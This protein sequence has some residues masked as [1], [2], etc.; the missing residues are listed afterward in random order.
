MAGKVLLSSAW[1]SKNWS[2]LKLLKDSHRANNLKKLVF[3][4]NYYFN[5][6]Q[7]SWNLYGWIE[8][9]ETHS[10]IKNFKRFGTISE[11]LWDKQALCKIS[12]FELKRFEPALKL[13]QLYE[14]TKTTAPR[15]PV[16][17]PNMVL[18]RRHF[19]S[20]R[21]SDGMRCFQSPMAVDKRNVYNKAI[22][23]SNYFTYN[24]STRL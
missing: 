23:H 7:Y 24:Q 9:D 3:L 21:R 1:I 20:L 18:T 4:E 15:I 12:W 2:D 19:D 14:K 17:S 22:F 11:E 8:L 10:V 6:V 16:W 13:N 5:L